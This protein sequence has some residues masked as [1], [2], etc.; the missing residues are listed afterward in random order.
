[1]YSHDCG[2]EV[3]IDDFDSLFIFII[4]K[5]FYLIVILKLLFYA[6][7]VNL[8]HFYQLNNF[9]NVEIFYFYNDLFKLLSVSFLAANLFKRFFVLLPNGKIKFLILLF[10]CLEL[11]LG[12]GASWMMQILLSII[13]LCWNVSCCSLHFLH[14][15]LNLIVSLHFMMMFVSFRCFLC[16]ELFDGKFSLFISDFIKKFMNFFEFHS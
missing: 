11:R 1:M 16:E 8:I 3:D 15:F 5:N 6:S 13:Y 12:L 2:I 9:L 14:P 7:K 10:L 4:F